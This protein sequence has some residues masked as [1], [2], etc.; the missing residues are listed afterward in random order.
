MIT[1]FLT[2]GILQAF[3]VILPGPDFAMVVKNTLGDS[4]RTGFYTAAGITA[5]ILFH[6]TYCLLGL[7]LIIQKTPLLFDF[8]KYLG[9]GYLIFIGIKTLTSSSTEATM[10]T[11]SSTLKIVRANPLSPIQAFSQGL[12]CNMLNPKAALFFLGVFT[13]AINPKTPKIIQTAYAIEI[14]AITFLW[15]TSLSFLLS[16]EQFTPKIQSFQG[17]ISKMM[18]VL[19]IFFGARLALVCF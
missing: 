1:G 11:P 3:A 10:N 13:L 15:F 12:L 7:A 17:M 5:G 14:M 2:I 16:H 4:R 9:A 19:L 8:I 6:M 18:G